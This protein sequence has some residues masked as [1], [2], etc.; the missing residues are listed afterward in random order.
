M[1]DVLFKPSQHSALHPGQAA[2]IYYKSHYLGVFGALHPSIV[3]ELGIVG[4]VFVFELF[5]DALEGLLIAH[6]AHRIELSKFPEIR[7]D[8]AIYV[9]Q[10][11]PSQQIQDTIVEVSGSLLKEVNV[12]DVYQGK[13]V[14]PNHKSIALTLILQHASRTLLDQEVA[15]IIVVVLSALKQR[16][17][18]ELRG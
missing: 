1:A 6:T 5:L 14:P 17:A 3:Q 4:N 2:D 15:D 13:G 16:F 18:A 11:V 12:F 7:R 9:D 10:T 8:I